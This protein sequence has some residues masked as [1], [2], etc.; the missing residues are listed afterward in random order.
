[1]HSFCFICRISDIPRQLGQT[2]EAE[3]M[4]TITAQQLSDNTTYLVNQMNFQRVYFQDFQGDASQTLCN[5]DGDSILNEFDKDHPFEVQ[6]YMN[7]GTEMQVVIIEGT[8]HIAYKID[9][10]VALDQ[11]KQEEELKANTI[12]ES[13][14]I[15]FPVLCFI[16]EVHSLMQQHGICPPMAIAQDVIN[17]HYELCNRKVYNTTEP[18]QEVIEQYVANATDLLGELKAIHLEYISK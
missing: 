8:P 14:P 17:K 1:M 3:A 15:K 11:W 4:Q 5:F 9:R 7:C 13:P 10:I 18:V 12:I 16:T 6:S 2:T